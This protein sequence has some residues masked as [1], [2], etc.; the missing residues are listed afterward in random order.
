MDIPFSTATIQQEAVQANA[1]VSEATW[2]AMGGAVNFI[3][4]NFIPVGTIIDSMLDEATFQSQT[5]TNW[6][7]CDGRS[8]LGST[9]Q[10]LTGNSTVP[11]CRGRYARAKD[12]GAGVDTHGDLALGAFESEQI[13]SHQHGGLLPYSGPGINV[14]L[15]GSDGVVHGVVSYTTGLT[16]SGETNPRSI[17][18]NKFIRI[19]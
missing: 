9:Y 16:G 5:N 4:A 18:I 12:N 19:N 10:T 14:G 15:G 1:P 6:V 7:L 17:V 8:V 2:S 13:Q 11:D 3:L